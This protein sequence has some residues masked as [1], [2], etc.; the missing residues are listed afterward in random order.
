MNLQVEYMP[1]G[2][3]LPYA[4]NAKEHPDW[5]NC[6]VIIE[7]WERETGREAVLDEQE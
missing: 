3:L 5:Q 6:D 7:R 1:I 2:Q 4:G